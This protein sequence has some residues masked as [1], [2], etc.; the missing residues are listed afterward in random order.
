LVKHYTFAL[1]KHKNKYKTTKQ[2]FEVMI[3][4]LLL[5]LIMQ[6]FSLTL[7]ANEKFLSTKLI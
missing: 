4:I 1:P 5:I 2:S 6:Y 7:L 3:V